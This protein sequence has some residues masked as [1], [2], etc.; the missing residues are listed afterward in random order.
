MPR[1]GLKRIFQ[2]ICFAW[3]ERRNGGLRWFHLK[4]MDE[5][6]GSLFCLGGKVGSMVRIV[7]V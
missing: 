1:L 7:L 2:G 3:G 6:K 4:W 5:I